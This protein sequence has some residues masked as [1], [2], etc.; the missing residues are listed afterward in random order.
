MQ[1]CEE[2][3]KP[4]AP[5]VGYI[6]IGIAP[7][8]PKGPRRIVRLH[9]NGDCLGKY[10]LTHPFKPGLEIEAAG[11]RSDPWK[12]NDRRSQTL[13]LPRTRF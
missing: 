2:C 8:V 1:E 7:E 9:S 13:R 3:G 5:N 4:I 6:D 12:L 11:E 10:R